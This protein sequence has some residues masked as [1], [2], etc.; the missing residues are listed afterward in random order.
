MKP[1]HSESHPPQ[2]RSRH[3]TEVR[4]A[5]PTSEPLK[6]VWSG[7]PHNDRDCRSRIPASVVIKAWQREMQLNGT[8]EGFFN[9]TWRHGEWLAYGLSDGGV[10]GIYCPTHRSER[11]SRGV[12]ITDRRSDLPRGAALDQEADQRA[13]AML[14]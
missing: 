10:R 9:F 13:G 4:S 8:V 14:Q 12:Q 3:L 6:C 1:P 2:P 5:E 11:E 7:Y